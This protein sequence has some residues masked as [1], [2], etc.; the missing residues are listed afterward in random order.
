MHGGRLCRARND[1]AKL[2]YASIEYLETIDIGKSFGI[3]IKTKFSFW[4][5][6]SN[7]SKLRIDFEVKPND[8]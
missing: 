4:K 1:L 8:R 7:K 2:E 6:V 5:C 3:R